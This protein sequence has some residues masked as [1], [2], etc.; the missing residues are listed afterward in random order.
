MPKIANT[1]V[2]QNKFFETANLFVDRNE[3]RANFWKL[4]NNYREEYTKNPLFVQVLAYCG[5]GGVGKTKLLH[6]IAKELEEKLGGNARHV[7]FDFNNS[8]NSI[9]VLTGIKNIL[10]EKYKFRFPLFELGLYALAQKN[11]QNVNA[12]ETKSFLDKSPSLGF[13]LDV[14]WELPVVGL[15]AKLAKVANT[16]ISLVSEM[17]QKHKESTLAIETLDPQELQSYLP[18]LF[19]K[20]LNDN[21]EKSKEALVILLDTY[22]QLVNEVKDGNSIRFADEWLKGDRGLVLNCHNVL[23]IVAGRERL[24]WIDLDVDW[25]GTL[26]QESLG[27]FSEADSMSYLQKAGVEEPAL[28]GQLCKLTSGVP[29]HLSLCVDVYNRIK[30]NS[31]VPTIADFGTSFEKLISLFLQRLEN[32]TNRQL[33]YLLSCLQM[34]DDALVQYVAED[35]LRNYSEASYTKLKILSFVTD[36]H[37]GKYNMHQTVSASVRR[38]PG[39]EYKSIRES[40]EQKA[41]EYAVSKLNNLSVLDSEHGY[42]LLWLTKF[43]VSNSATE[44]MAENRFAKFADSHWQKLLQVGSFDLA[45]NILDVLQYNDL[46][47]GNSWYLANVLSMRALALNKKKNEV[48]AK[49]IGHDATEMYRNSVKVKNT[50]YGYR[51]LNA[52]TKFMYNEQEEFHLRL[53]LID[54]CCEMFGVDD[55]KVEKNI[56]AISSILMLGVPETVSQ[57][58][59]NLARKKIESVEEKRYDIRRKKEEIRKVEIIQ[60]LQEKKEKGCF[61]DAQT[62]SMVFELSE[63]IENEEESLKFKK[64]CVDLCESFIEKNKDSDHS[65]VFLDVCAVY[66][67]LDK[68]GNSKQSRLDISKKKYKDF[69]KEKANKLLCQA[70][71]EDLLQCL[72]M[73]REGLYSYF[74]KKDEVYHKLISKILQCYIALYGENSDE[75]ISYVGLLLNA[76]GK[77]EKSL[78]FETFYKCIDIRVRYLQNRLSCVQETANFS[79]ISRIEIEEEICNLLWKKATVEYEAPY[80]AE[81][82]YAR[83]GQE[84]IRLHETLLKHRLESYGNVLENRNVISHLVQLY[85]GKKDVE[86]AVEYRK[87]LEKTIVSYFMNRWKMRKTMYGESHPETIGCLE[88]LA[89]NLSLLKKFDKSIETYD[90]V[91]CLSRNSELCKGVNLKKY[92]SY[93]YTVIGRMIKEGKYKESVDAALLKYLVNDDFVPELKELDQLINEYNEHQFHSTIPGMDDAMAFMLEFWK[94][95]DKFVN[96]TDEISKEMESDLNGFVEKIEPLLKSARSIM[97]KTFI[98]FMNEPLCWLLGMFSLWYSMLDC[99]DESYACAKEYCERCKL[100]GYKNALLEFYAYVALLDGYE[101][102]E[103]QPELLKCA[104]LILELMLKPDRMLQD[105]QL[106]QT[107]KIYIGNM[108]TKVFVDNNQTE[109]MLTC[110]NMVMDMIQ[111]E[112]VVDPEQKAEA[113]CMLKLAKEKMG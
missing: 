108:L 106:F 46:R 26:V 75:T 7:Y 76:G 20:D 78:N 8:Q 97:D 107:I 93:I 113:E 40:I 92:Y 89:F 24:K 57:E 18:N 47:Q 82:A 1:S 61:L 88:G 73:C 11:G 105:N 110:A 32:E 86:K 85:E 34:W 54:M 49:K 50:E 56:T 5:I 51:I 9:E 27:Q 22:E 45:F 21:T 28:C 2:S 53:F 3:P 101:K 100:T 4:Y 39:V 70:P 62:I 19:A 35:V 12:P 87:L 95:S 58:E 91:I 67:I 94:L 96:K 68:C 81:A 71:S 98:K 83:I 16:G 60:Q 30:E 42:W 65:Q 15:C 104:N 25:E 111:K 23:W 103:N 48:E 37:D 77:I 102:T 14:A 80:S 59:V 13:M 44:E 63:L 64:K 66:E 6:K 38:S 84:G 36:T 31:G 74:D 109:R 112:S 72:R 10:I 29:I 17:L 33:V 55:E 69:L 41:I 90:K 52:F 79:Y 43:I 99:D